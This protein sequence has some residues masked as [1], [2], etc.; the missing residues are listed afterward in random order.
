[1]FECVVLHPQNLWVEGIISSRWNRNSIGIF[2]NFIDFSLGLG[3]EITFDDPVNLNQ[4]V[5]L[6][7]YKI[8]LP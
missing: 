7:G 3:A 4:K 8:S 2:I 1:M 5:K 6:D